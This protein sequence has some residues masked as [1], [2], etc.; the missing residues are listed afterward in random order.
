MIYSG[1]WDPQNDIKPPLT[2]KKSYLEYIKNLTI[3]YE[4]QTAQKKNRQKKQTRKPDRKAQMAHKHMK[5]FKVISSYSANKIVTKIA[6]HIHTLKKIKL[7][8]NT[9][10]WQGC[11]TMQINN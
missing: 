10:C 6:F 9:K 4:R 1:V 11:S 5:T 8:G 2:T 7:S 3:N